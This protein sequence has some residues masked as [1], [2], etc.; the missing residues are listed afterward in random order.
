[1]NN[2]RNCMVTFFRTLQESRTCYD[3][4][5]NDCCPAHMCHGQHMDELIKAAWSSHPWP[6]YSNSKDHVTITIRCASA[7]KVVQKEAAERQ[8]LIS[9]KTWRELRP[10]T[11]ITV[12][13]TPTH[14]YISTYMQQT[15][16][17]AYVCVYIYIS[18]TQCIGIHACTMH[19]CVCIYIIIYIYTYV[20]M[21]M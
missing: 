10:S 3:W 18:C 9:M 14:T 6:W 12:T 1:M 16:A 17:Y 2:P 11:W 21:H 15:H 8:V 13:Y 4:W 19:V 7:Q 20:G 5:E